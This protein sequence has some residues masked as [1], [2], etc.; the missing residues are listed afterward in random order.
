MRS[1][2]LIKIIAVAILFIMWACQPKGEQGPDKIHLQ[3]DESVKVAK[4]DRQDLVNLMTVYFDALVSQDQSKVPIASNIKFVENTAE[5]PVGNGL[6]VTA[7]GGPGKFRIDAADPEAQQVASLA[8]M[9][10]N[11]DQDAF[12]GIR[13]KV[14]NGKITEAEHLVL[15]GD[16][17]SENNISNLQKP[18]TG[19]LEDVNEDDQMPREE[20][21]R[22]GL[23]YYDAV[24]G[25]D[26][27]LAPFS[28]ECERYENGMFSAGPKTPQGPNPIAEILQTPP[29]MPTDCECQISTG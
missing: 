16:N 17:L 26:G 28:K 8:M 11:N 25:E 10:E 9:K 2:Q 18:R 13:L 1:K 20:L 24:T 23:A 14:E 21:I 29:S 3:K 4:L 7:S 12:V 22:I 27:T 19:L 6:W 15:H 5:M